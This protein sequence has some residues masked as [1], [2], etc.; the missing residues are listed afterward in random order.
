MDFP[1]FIIQLEKLQE[2]LI[3]EEMTSICIIVYTYIYERQKKYG[4]KLTC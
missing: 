2:A 1:I 3:M 4:E